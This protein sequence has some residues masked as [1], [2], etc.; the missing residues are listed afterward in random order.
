MLVDRLDFSC[1]FCGEW[2]DVDLDPAAGRRQ[3]FVE[4][5]QVCCRPNVLEV[6]LDAEGF[7]TVNVQPES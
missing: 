1:A 6:T 5:C 7:P 2:M 4:D 3:T